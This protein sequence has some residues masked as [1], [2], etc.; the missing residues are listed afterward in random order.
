MVE[1]SPTE[2]FD[3][4]LR[5]VEAGL[6]A[7]MAARI[8]AAAHAA[9]ATARAERRRVARLFEVIESTGEL[10]AVHNVDA[11]LREI[12]SRARRL[13]DCDYVYLNTPEPAGDT[14]PG[15]RGSPAGAGVTSS[16]P[17]AE[18]VSYAIRAWSGDLAP[19]FLGIPV[20]PGLGV[21]GVVLQTG[22]PYQVADYATTR[23][24]DTPADYAELLARQQISTLLATP[25]VV[26]GRITG[27][28]FAARTHE[29]KFS[30]DEV[31][32]LSALARHAA[33]ALQN[34][35]LDE[36]RERA[37]R[38]V[39]V[40]AE[41]SE[42]KRAEEERQSRLHARLNAVVLDGAGVSEVLAAVGE[43]A[44]TDVAYV[45]RTTG[46]AVVASTPLTPTTAASW[47]LPEP[48]VLATP[49]GELPRPELR[50]VQVGRRRWAVI[51]VVAY[52]RAVGH[53]VTRTQALEDPATAR[54]L[55][56]TSQAVALCQL[57]TQALADA[58]RRTA[59]EVVRKLVSS[60][61]PEL[62]RKLQRSGI[63]L[64]GLRILLCDSGDPSRE[65]R[66]T[67]WTEQHNGMAAV[68]DEVAVVLAPAESGGP[69]ATLATEL[70]GELGEIV[71]LSRAV[72]D[73]ELIR[74]EFTHTLRSL[75][76]AHALGYTGE[77]VRVE[78]FGVFSMLFTD[79]TAEDLDD[80][81]R[82]QA[83][84]LLDSD[85]RHGTA[86]AATALALLDHAGGVRA[87]AADLDVH[88]N[89]ITQRAGRISRLLGPGWRDQPRAFEV[90]AGLKLHR[91]RSQA[92]RRG[93]P[94]G[95]VFS[96][97]PPDRGR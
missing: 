46:T 90:H 55:Q 58:E 75:H 91:L 62:R 56:W 3:A 21:G 54:L 79:P 31:F 52:N 38:E 95:R 39:S 68:V 23:P 28:L 4:R 69:L 48:S 76:L 83:G 24:A 86:L 36:R 19:E 12:T 20:S 10:V 60:S 51:D 6:D 22:Q 25:L 78:Q 18:P 15:G 63:G 44:G 47:T 87:A 71:V 53:L 30:D 61:S 57:S 64:D 93:Q 2:E 14:A 80:F 16:V 50:E 74:P 92:G 34:A 11:V 43:E 85:D 33:I 49:R 82:A 77:V 17:A 35:E 70:S 29:E 41:Q 66:L 7:K 89:T 73:L 94:G 84:P 81:I 67:R 42:A 40:A 65:R 13:L 59:T 88:P 26:G 32:L 1:I 9:R 37:L 96:A 97:A 8:R 5:A 27:L 72:V 45:D